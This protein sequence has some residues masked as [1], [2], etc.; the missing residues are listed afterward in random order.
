MIGKPPA[1]DDDS[2]EQAVQNYLDLML[3]P[4][5]ESASSQAVKPAD[6]GSDV[7]AGA[8]KALTMIA[9]TTVSPIPASR[10]QRHGDKPKLKPFADPVKALTLK[11]PLSTI[12]TS[13]V[14]NTD[15]CPT[16]SKALSTI[17]TQATVLDPVQEQVKVSEKP[18]HAKVK[19]AEKPV[20]AKQV[21]VEPDLEQE[22]LTSTSCSAAEQST[23]DA[24][25]ASHRTSAWLDN[26]R[27]GWAQQRFDCLLFT[28]G[29]L[30][31]AVPLVELGTIYP[32]HDEITPLF[33]QADWFLGL[34]SVKDGNIRTV[35]T[36]K[37][38]M[39]ERYSEAM[40]QGL[41]YVITIHGVDWGL[42]VHSVET[43]ITLDPEDVR[44]RSERS[45]RPWL[46]G[47]VVDK[48]CALLDVSQLAALFIQQD[49][50][51]H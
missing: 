34:L 7:A 30:T 1:K 45:K 36:A 5:G 8:T 25:L 19:V 20:Q 15:T 21:S 41:S 29:G 50:R 43:A 14:P 47:T 17:A 49:H 32:L 2:P 35:N 24:E 39:P 27:P 26:G 11:M 12:N 10:Q 9:G 42:A 51:A 23:R 4:G 16:D 37:V 6:S 44:W 28:V 38:V 33:G 3:T 40:E 31:L 13:V 18:V 22:V 48:M 46:A